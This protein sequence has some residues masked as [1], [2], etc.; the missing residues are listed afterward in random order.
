MNDE[1]ELSR[2]ARHWMHL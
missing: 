2:T 1:N